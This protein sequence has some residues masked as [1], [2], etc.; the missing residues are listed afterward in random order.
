M[1]LLIVD[2]EELTRTGVISSIDWQ[3]LG[4]NEVL[5]ADDGLNGFETARMYKPEIILCDV[6][7]PRMDG[8]TMLE[9][10]EKILP[11][12]VPIFM[13]GYSD[14]GY[15][16]AAIK[17]KAVNYIEKP[18]NPQEIREAILEAKDLYI[19]KVRSHQGESMETLKNASRLAMMLTSPYSSNKEQI[20]RLLLELSLPVSASTCCT[21]VVVHLRYAPELAEP[22][23]E[24][25][26]HSFKELLG[27]YHTDCIYVAKRRQY[28]VYFIF[29]PSAPSET[30]QSTVTDFM[31]KEYPRYGDHFIAVGETFTGIQRA[32]QSY[33]SAV[34]LLESSFFFPVNSIL[35]PK[36]IEELPSR[37]IE[38]SAFSP[39]ESFAGYLSGQNEKDCLEFLDNLRKFS[40]RNKNILPDQIKDLYYKFFIN[41]EN[42]RKQQQ[43]PSAKSEQNHIVAFLENY[44][45]Y[46]ELHDT[47]VS[48]T[49]EFFS[50]LKNAS[51]ENPT[52]FLI[53]DYISKNYMNETLSVKDISAH[54]FLSTSY[55]C[56]FFKNETGRTL[57]QYLTEY[58]MEKA[59]SLLADPRYKITDISSKVGY[60]DGN[61]FGKSFK[62]YTG[63]SPSEYREKMSL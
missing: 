5:Q 10:L 60:S 56:T 49:K 58:R 28:L 50:D 14:K 47:L 16:K 11:D 52:I 17:L 62:K 63:F 22:S 19:Q 1:K 51:P 29:S 6:R 41:L 20:D 59:K 12:C 18:I 2:D 53:K 46:A 15:L 35:T 21:S 54:V 39:E 45:T 34:V 27:H 32:Y 57:N 4:I 9:K 31:E 38:D 44:F 8:I 61:Y 36:I 30:L 40:D 26:Y 24:E 55:V 25:L 43:L 33:T 7:M 3:S 23:T 48:E 42:A 13:S 37:N